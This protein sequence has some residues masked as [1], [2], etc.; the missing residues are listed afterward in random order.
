[1]T[2]VVVVDD[3]A[4]IREGGGDRV[5]AS[6]LDVVDSRNGAEAITK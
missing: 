3:E 2:T 4:L 1:M 5:G 6:G